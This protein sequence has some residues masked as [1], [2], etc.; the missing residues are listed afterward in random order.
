MPDMIDLPDV[1]T[2]MSGG[3]GNWLAGQQAT[4]AETR[5]KIW[6]IG[7]SAALLGAIVASAGYLL[8]SPPVALFLGGLVAMAGAG[9]AAYLRQQMINSLK[10]EMNGA[11]ARSLGIEYQVSPMSG[12]E[13][14]LAY[15]F[16]LLPSYDDSYLQDAWNG[17]AG[18]VDFL[19]YEA[20]LTETRGS[21]KNRR[22]V[23]VFQG[24]LLRMR[25]ARDFIGTTLVRR[26][27][28]KFI[29]FGDS[30]DYA[31]QTLERIKMVDPRFEDAFDVYSNDQVEGRY[32]VHPAYCERLLELER[33]FFGERLCALFHNGD[34]LVTIHTDDLFESATLDPAKDRQLLGQTID[35][36]AAITRLIET[37]NERPR[38]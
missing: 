24:I 20:K 1:D 23:T 19:L 16:D 11:L 13:F 33:D 30:K 6:T 12:P 36:F 35:Q 3:L 5:R 29:L 8:V 31:G 9:W 17:M 22:T 7:V 25:F 32:L 10:H 27:G 14:D 26:D 15:E 18:G 28:F 2:L 38:G 21:G 37:L 4:R 34:L